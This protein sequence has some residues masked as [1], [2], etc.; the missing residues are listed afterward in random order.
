MGRENP[1]YFEEFFGPVSMVIRVKDE[2]E[3]MAVAKDSPF[4]LGGS[5]FTK[6][7]TPLTSTR[8][9][10][11]DPQQPAPN[12]ARPL[13]VVT[14]L[15]SQSRSAMGSWML[16]DWTCQQSKPCEPRRQG[17]DRRTDG[18]ERGLPLAGMAEEAP[19]PRGS[20]LVVAD[21]QDWTSGV[22]DAVFADRAEQHSGERPVPPTPYHQQLGSLSRFE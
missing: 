7:S 5:V 14:L 3:A 1:A 16:T 18:S 22:R 9:S 4:G 8:R 13:A 11:L 10:D 20:V 21:H 15:P 17:R 2:A 6:S 19:S 12:R